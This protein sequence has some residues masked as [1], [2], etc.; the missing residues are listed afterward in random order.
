VSEPRTLSQAEYRRLSCAV[1]QILQAHRGARA[2]ITGVELAKMLGFRN[3]RLIRRA[4]QRMIE[5]DCVTIAASVHEPYGYYLIETKEEGDI[6]E[7]CLRSRAAKTLTRLSKFRRGMAAKFG[8]A[9]Q[10]SLF[11]VDAAL[12][13]L[14]K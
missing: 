13:E 12:K 5:E 4:I 3:D 1:L 9:Y 8:P 6:Y 10:M 2:A 14:R 7:A 11:Y